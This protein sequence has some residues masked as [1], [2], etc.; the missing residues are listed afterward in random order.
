MTHVRRIEEK[1]A[2]QTGTWFPEK[3]L[4]ATPLLHL[5][6]DCCRALWKIILSTATARAACSL[7]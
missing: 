5:H 7:V 1:R 2:E 4:L 6:K 3:V